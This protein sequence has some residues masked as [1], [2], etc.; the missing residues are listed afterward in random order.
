MKTAM[1]G[2][3]LSLL[4]G[5][6]IAPIDGGYGPPLPVYDEAYDPP[7]LGFQRPPDVIVLPDTDDVYVV[8]EINLDLFFWNGW[9]WRP[10]GGRWYRS[11]FYDR[12]WTHY[13][14]VPSFYY[15]VDPAWRQYYKNRNWY[16]HRWNYE[17]IPNQRLQQ[18]WGPW[19]E[20]RHW[21]R[22][23]TW[24][25]QGYQ[26]RPP[27]QREQLRYQRQEQYHRETQKQQREGLQ[28]QR[29]QRKELQRQQRERD[30]LQRQ[31][32]QR[33][34]LKQ[35]ERDQREA[36]ERQQREKED[37]QR[38]QREELQKQRQEEQQRKKDHLKRQQQDKQELQRR[39][40]EE[41]QWEKDR[42]PEG[43][44]HDYRGKLEG[45]DTES[46]R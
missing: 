28:R 38:R 31:Q 4:V 27:Q 33:E 13:S 7:P 36:V 43:E 8:P 30:E 46:R 17:R 3:V 18:N 40:K 12:G 45:S 22:Q 44:S 21:E 32:R 41:R 11:Q 26:P 16:G 14:G 35:R 15:D 10:S 9:W 20:S 2:L 25:V 6:V 34:E 42:R 24:G 23:R 39:E 5:C 29:D 19:R 37:L 1:I